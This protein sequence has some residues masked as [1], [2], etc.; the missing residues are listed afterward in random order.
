MTQITLEK[1][2]HDI[3]EIKI[4]LHKITNLLEKELEL[5]DETKK[6]LKEARKQPLSEY[7]SHDEVMKEFA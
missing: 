6:E 5:S 4:Q 2:G 1:V 7:I 3:E